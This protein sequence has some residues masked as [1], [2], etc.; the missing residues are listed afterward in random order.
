MVRLCSPGGK[1]FPFRGISNKQGQQLDTVA[2]PAR[3]SPPF[4]MVDPMPLS[5]ACT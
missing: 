2:S 1:F 4:K 5:E 3:V